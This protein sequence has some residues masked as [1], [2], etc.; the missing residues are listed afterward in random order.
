MKASESGPDADKQVVP[1]RTPKKKGQPEARRA[2]GYISLQ[3]KPAKEQLPRVAQIHEKSLAK[4][5][6]TRT[7]EDGI[8]ESSLPGY[9]QRLAS[10]LLDLPCQNSSSKETNRLHRVEVAR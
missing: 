6:G 3:D 7:N 10:L 5:P 2:K 1:F 9:H 4:Y 8:R